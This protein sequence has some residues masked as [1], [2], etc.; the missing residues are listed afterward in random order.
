[1]AFKRLGTIPAGLLKY[2]LMTFFCLSFV[3]TVIHVTIKAKSQK[4]LLKNFEKKSLSK[5]DL[6]HEGVI[7]ITSEKIND[8]LSTIKKLSRLSLLADSLD[9]NDKEVT[10]SLLGQYEGEHFDNIVVLDN[11]GTLIFILKIAEDNVGGDINADLSQRDYFK[12]TISTKQP[13]ISDIFYS[14][15]N[16]Y[17]I[18]FSSPIFDSQGEVKYVIAGSKRLQNMLVDF[19]FN[20]NFDYFYSF[21][22]DRQGYLITDGKNLITEKIDL[23][24]EQPFISDFVQ[25]PKEKFGE[26]VDRHGEKQYVK[27]SILKFT[28]NSSFYLISYFP[29]SEYNGEVRDIETEL[30]S[31]FMLVTI[32]S[33]G[34]FVFCWYLTYLYIR[35]NFKDYK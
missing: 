8:K 23:K 32:I 22:V 20:T 11:K 6:Y 14:V 12:N 24:K 34:L 4:I 15:T 21:L 25:F 7:R 31:G 18:I 17:S 29:L 27:G 28:P 33:L 16:Y 35:N 26:A 3:L 9:R 2:V 5:L 1:M 10:R 19:N 30:N 13:Y